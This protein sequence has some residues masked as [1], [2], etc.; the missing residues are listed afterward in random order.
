[1]LTRTQIQRAARRNG[2]GPQIQERDYLQHVFLRLLYTRSQGLALGGGTALHAVYGGNRFS[3]DLEFT[4]LAPATPAAEIRRRLRKAVR[5]MEGYGI[6]AQIQREGSDDVRPL[7]D[8][9][10]HGPLYDGKSR[11]ASRIRIAVDRGLA[12]VE[13]RRELVASRY[14]DVRPFVVTALTPEQLM[15]HTIRAVMVLGRPVDLY[16]LWLMQGMAIEPQHRLIERRL[17][18]DEMGWRLRDLAD[19]IDIVRIGW[20][21]DLRHLLPQYVPFETVKQ[22]IIRWLAGF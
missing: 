8:I 16:D 11:S 13:V 5:E 21:R 14:D 6:A 1:V 4:A 22:G 7:V 9:L 2:I 18:A 3:E 19:G 15:A 10:L 17:A 12:E 20:E